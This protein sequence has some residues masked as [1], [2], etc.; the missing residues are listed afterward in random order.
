MLFGKVRFVRLKRLFI[1]TLMVTM[2]I[3]MAVF[4]SNGN[5]VPTRDY[6]DINY[7]GFPFISNDTSSIYFKQELINVTFDSS[8]AYF[9]ADYTFKNND[10]TPLNMTITLP[11]A[12]HY[13]YSKKPKN[14]ILTQDQENLPYSWIKYPYDII[15]IPSYAYHYSL[16]AILF[17]LTFNANEEITVHVKYSRNYL[18]SRRYGCEYRY[19][20]GTARSWNHSIESAIFEFQIPKRICNNLSRAFDG[21]REE[22]SENLFHKI[23]EN[24]EFYIA[25]LYFQNWIPGDALN[26]I[27]VD[28]ERDF[29]PDIYIILIFVIGILAFLFILAK[30]HIR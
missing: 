28:W 3:N 20:V 22:R 19:L 17:N 27:V 1:I 23:R 24:D 21:S 18:I 25:N 15:S 12:N 29:P 11:F 30:K 13:N 9:Q 4:T 26:M 8:K 7:E 5:P 6:T 10:S 16:D 2:F 14:I